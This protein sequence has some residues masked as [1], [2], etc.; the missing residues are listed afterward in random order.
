MVGVTAKTIV[1][2]LGEGDA[3]S[4]FPKVRSYV[5]RWSETNA[6]AS[7]ITDVGEFTKVRAHAVIQSSTAASY[8]DV[9]RIIVPSVC[10]C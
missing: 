2:S 7:G 8:V 9:C 5:Q 10:R 6:F 4:A 3:M 1:D